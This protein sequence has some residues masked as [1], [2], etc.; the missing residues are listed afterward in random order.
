[1]KNMRHKRDF[2]LRRRCDPTHLD[3]YLR[4]SCCAPLPVLQAYHAAAD[5]HAQ[6]LHLESIGHPDFCGGSGDE[7]SAPGSDAKALKLRAVE[8][9]GAAKSWNQEISTAK[10]ANRR[11]RLLDGP[12]LLQFVQFCRSRKL[13]DVLPYV[14]LC[15]PEAMTA[16]DALT[17]ALRGA[18]AGTPADI[19]SPSGLQGPVYLARAV[20][21]IRSIAQTLGARSII[22]PEEEA[23]ENVPS[24]EDV[25]DEAE[26][27]AQVGG[28]GGISAAAAASAAEGGKRV[29]SE[30]QVLREVQVSRQSP[31]LR[32]TPRGLLSHPICIV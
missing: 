19:V 22:D 5:V 4:H 23:K 10:A 27:Q 29:E 8:L 15:F 26:L 14:L 9:K 3:V 7:K 11:L 2:S 28:G 21:L 12:M 1:M 30:A 13:V 18:L 25:A 31:P 24:L 32:D 16:R 17:D 20:A 6:R